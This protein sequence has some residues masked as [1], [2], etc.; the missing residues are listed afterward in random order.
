MKDLDL[1][2][3]K[4]I[5]LETDNSGLFPKRGETILNYCMWDDYGAI[6]MEYPNVFIDNNKDLNEIIAHIAS[7]TKIRNA[8]AHHGRKEQSRSSGVG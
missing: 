1:S 7:M 4:A 3:S 8:I 6:M 5:R 2:R